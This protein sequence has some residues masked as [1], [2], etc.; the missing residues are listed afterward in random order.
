MTSL[1][2]PYWQWAQRTGYRYLLN[3]ASGSVR[4][5]LAPRG[6]KTLK[7]IEEK[8]GAKL[9]LTRAGEPGNFAS[10]WIGKPDVK[11]LKKLAKY[12]EFVLAEPGMR[13]AGA[14][15]GQ[16][17]SL[18]EPKGSCKP[19][20]T[21]LVIGV[22]D[23]RCGFANK[24]FC[25]EDFPQ[26]RIDY[27]WDQGNEPGEN[28]GQPKGFAY[29]RE[30]DRI[31]LDALLE[32]HLSAERVSGSRAEAEKLLYGFLKHELPADADWS[33]G[34]HVLD[35]VLS[36]YS[37]SDGAAK[38]SRPGVVYV[39][40][41][42][43]AL[44]DTSGR[45]AAS[46]V[47]DALHYVLD[48]AGAKARV[49]VNLSL[50]SFAGP[51]DGTS[52][53]ERAIDHLIKSHPKKPTVVVAAG[54]AGRVL[55]DGSGEPKACHARVTLG[56]NGG[57]KHDE[58]PS[59]DLKCVVDVMDTTETFIE[60]WVPKIGSD[61]KPASVK[62]S[63]ECS[64]AAA[65]PTKERPLVALAG[66]TRGWPSDEAAIAAVINA[67]GNH[68][69]PNGSGGMV[70]VALAH[71]RGSS[72]LCAPAGTWIVKVTNE[73][74]VP[75]TLDAWIERRDVPGELRGYRPQ[76]G[77]SADTP[78]TTTKG[79]L[80]TLANGGSTVVAGA[81]DWD[82]E[83]EAD[84]YATS[85]YC[86]LGMGGIRGDCNARPVARFGPD[87]YGVGKREATGFLSGS[88]KELAGTSM[89]AA[90]VTAALASAATR[91]SKSQTD[92]SRGEILDALNQ[93]AKVRDRSQSPRGAPRLAAIEGRL[94]E[95]VLPLP[96]ALQDA[97]RGKSAGPP[98][99]P[100]STTVPAMR[101]LGQRRRSKRART[102]PPPNPSSTDSPFPLNTPAGSQS[103]GA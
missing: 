60:I 29:G 82:H 23:G 63:L 39:Q 92:E 72:E 99:A 18:N 5:M 8:V 36:D 56:A 77:F 27:F 26:S 71:T 47:L 44:R 78:G 73:S 31:T 95:P 1:L 62:V 17:K 103:P 32:R 66:E 12:A 87:I 64:E 35:T 90:Q 94:S 65:G 16:A 55:D 101:A 33:H 98:A 20:D 80:G 49:I 48:R 97:L 84:A 4:L 93:E 11:T 86:S 43:D 14:A 2:D 100:A 68:N 25:I 42:D 50:G 34:T 13:P 58:S 51:H 38:A 40:L 3:D 21:D 22:I 69:V 24:K 28:W 74:P 52:L 30:L 96:R 45:W 10:A 79:S 85:P 61:G 46:Y 57:S 59:V 9:Q 53:L 88:K 76:Y 70:L 6:K 102:P 75:I 83:A 41:P 54:N 67:T 37:A 91:R 89:A 81:A 19:V 15:R 7:D